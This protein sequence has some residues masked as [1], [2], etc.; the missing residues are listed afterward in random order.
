[1]KN[2]EINPILTL[3]KNEKKKKRILSLS[4]NFLSINKPLFFNNNSQKKNCQK[5]IQKSF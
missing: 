4:P 2:K 5:K 3:I 1:M